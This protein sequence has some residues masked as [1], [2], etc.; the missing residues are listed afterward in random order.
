L[1][2]APPPSE[3]A[4]S[5]T[6]RDWDQATVRSFY[7]EYNRHM[8]RNLMIHEAMPGHALQLMHAN[9]YPGAT[10][11]RAVWW[12]GTFVEGWAVYAEELMVARGYR[13]DESARA[14]A[15]LRMQQ[16]KMRLR[17]ILNAV[18]DIRFHCDDLSEDEAMLLMTARGYQEVGEATG[19]WRRVQLTAA[20][21]CTY[22]V[23]VQEVSELVQDV[24]A[25]RPGAADREIHDAVLA[26][27]APPARHVRR[28]V[29][30]GRE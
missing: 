8:L 24:R 14:A 23:G 15:A 18:L 12:S 10:P 17:T 26:H 6:P 27:G 4:V 13:A 16:L 25:A 2:T 19:K 11:I 20:Q 22:Y 7:R 3:V 21:L 28:L 5:P 29:L 30:A 1:E 9:R